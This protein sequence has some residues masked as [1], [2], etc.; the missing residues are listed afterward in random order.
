MYIFNFLREAE[1]CDV[2]TSDSV[3]VKRRRWEPPLLQM[4]I[5]I[6][7]ARYFRVLVAVSRLFFP[8]YKLPV[9]MAILPI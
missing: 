4:N 7:V 8:V 9:K 5:C 6:F 2:K 3:D 1:R